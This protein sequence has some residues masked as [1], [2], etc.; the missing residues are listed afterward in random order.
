MKNL[1]KILKVTALVVIASLAVPALTLAQGVYKLAA[2]PGVVIKVLGSSNV[3]DWVMASTVMD[4][5]GEFTVTGETLSSLKKL[6][7]QLAFNSLKS[8]HETMDERMYKSVN[9]SKFPN[10]TYKLLSAT[11]SGVTKDKFLIATKGELTIAGVTQTISMDVNALLNTDN[12]ITCS[13]SEKIKLTDYG[14]KPPTF[15]LG[16][17]KVYNDLTIQFNLIYKK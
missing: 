12:S 2:G 16:A 13:G 10:I 5:K 9:E 7:F 1:N 17:M 4:S 8:E 15:M 11:V 6:S 3:H 14:I